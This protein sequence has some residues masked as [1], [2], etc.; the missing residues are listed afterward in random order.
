MRA[1]AP[2]TGARKGERDERLGALLGKGLLLGDGL[3]GDPHKGQV[4]SHADDKLEGLPHAGAPVKAV[5]SRALVT[6]GMVQ[7]TW[8]MQ[9][10]MMPR[11]S[12]H[13]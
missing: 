11:R 4:D 9:G 6:G 13:R 3:L 5:A 8:A 10:L 12:G 1:P 2:R 7:G